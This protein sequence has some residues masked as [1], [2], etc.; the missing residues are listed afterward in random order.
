MKVLRSERVKEY[1]KSE[2]VEEL[3]GQHEL[4]RQQTAQR[5]TLGATT[6]RTNGLINAWRTK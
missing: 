3:T 2:S 5:P 6:L 4:G 1:K